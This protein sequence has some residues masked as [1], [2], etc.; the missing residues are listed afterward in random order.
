MTKL[1]TEQ[2]T[3]IEAPL[4]PMSVI[5]CAGSGKTLTA[6]CRLAEIRK[7]LG[8]HRGRVALLSFSNV[9]VNTFRQS[10]QS[11]AQ[12]LSTSIRRD[13]VEIDTLDGF[14][15]CNVL[16]PHAYRT[17]GATHAAFLVTGGESFLSGYRFKTNTY[18]L[19]IARMQ[20]GMRHD[21]VYF[22]HSNNDQM[23]EL[24]AT[25]ASHV[26]HR[27]GRTGAY[28][29]N[30][31]RYW[32]Y[33]VLREQSAV[34]RA[35]AHRYPHI[36][37]DESQDIGTL[38]QAILEQL[39]MAGAQVSLI[40]DPH[41]GIYEFAGANGKFLTQYGER[42]EV[43]GYGLTRNYRSVAAILKLAN[44]LSARSDIAE[45]QASGTPHSLY[46]IAYRN[47]ERG[48]LITTFQAAVRAAGLRVERS[49][50]LCRGRDLADK[51][52]GNHATLGQGIIKGFAQAAILRDKQQDYL[53]AFKLVT[54]CIVGLLADPPQ[55]LVSMIV[56][57][58]R[59]REA[60]PLRRIIWNFT[61]NPYK[62]LPTATLNAYTHWH[63]QLLAR[64]K[65]L[66]SALQQKFDLP[67]A[68][69][70][71][72]KMTKKGLPNAPLINAG[73]LADG[74]DPRIRVDTVHQVK[75]ESLDAVL[76]LAA[77]DHV[78]ALLAGVD[79]EIGRIGYVAVTR[80]RNL[81]WLGVPASALMELR[82]ALLAHGFQE[83]GVTSVHPA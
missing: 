8:D 46:F 6:V 27:L 50:V 57:D 47:A 72:H 44:K 21:K 82:P 30:L 56:H 49:A 38:H 83:I 58:T 7:R 70:L 69:N 52:A 26:V 79:T 22:Y 81:L 20:V 9:A 48:Q 77:K 10:Y 2:R 54:N 36:L 41:Q 16:R 55:G 23:E 11:L 12:D 71:G 31:G 60:R 33:R 37:I 32:C 39:I 29:H 62:G 28:T 68:D 66:L 59:Y 34:L 80:A 63:P 4:E 24:N 78:T 3:I 19:S 17:M 13:R 35:L 40:G 53:E 51:L 64:T 61:R 76:Y 75:G 5:A 73:S 65:A 74:Q 67:A 45:R 14:F 43:K 42:A 15:T 1:S 18:P 25:Y